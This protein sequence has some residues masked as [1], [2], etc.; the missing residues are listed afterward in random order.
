MKKNVLLIFCSIIIST[1]FSEPLELQRLVTS[2]VIIPCCAKHASQLFNLVTLYEEQT[3]LPDEIVISLSES[4]KVPD[5]IILALQTRSWKFPVKLLL[6]EK[7]LYAGQ[8]RNIACSNAS[9]D[10]FICQDADDIPHPQR[11]EIIKYFFEHY[12][13]DHLMHEWFE[14]RE[15]DLINFNQYQD[16]KNINFFWP[17]KFKDIGKYGRFTNGNVAIRRQIFEKITWSD[18]PRGQDTKFNN[19]VYNIS[20]QCILIKCILLA[21]RRYLSTEN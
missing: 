11:V 13:I 17:R 14:A 1:L 21:Y 6:S 10:I 3:I 5:D 7:K 12:D 16:L 20:N 8:N 15:N 18:L 19:Q 2:S 9:G 4:D